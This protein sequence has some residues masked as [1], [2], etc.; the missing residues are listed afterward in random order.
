MK[1]SLKFTPKLRNVNMSSELRNFSKTEGGDDGGAWVGDRGGL[2]NELT[3]L[4]KFLG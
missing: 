1:R 2:I 4:Q 3:E